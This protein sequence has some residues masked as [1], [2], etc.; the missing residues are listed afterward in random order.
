MEI[1]K[2]T[3]CDT[4]ILFICT[5]ILILDPEIMESVLME[6]PDQMIKFKAYKRVHTLKRTNVTGY[7]LTRV[8]HQKRLP[9]GVWANIVVESIL[10]I[11]FF[12]KSSIVTKVLL[13]CCCF[14]F[15]LTVI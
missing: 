11:F 2:N 1:S 14:P 6:V 8:S 4:S 10:I 9:Y 15:S 3:P 5:F 13:P 7:R 12:F